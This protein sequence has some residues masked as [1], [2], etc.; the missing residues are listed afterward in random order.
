MSSFGVTEQRDPCPFIKVAIKLGANNRL[1]KESRHVDYS[2]VLKGGV[3]Y[4]G[5]TLA[6]FLYQLQLCSQ[7]LVEC[8][9]CSDCVH[10]EAII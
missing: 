4:L 1:R 5:R 8:C 7:Y 10:F 6:Q 3:C 2:F 9:H